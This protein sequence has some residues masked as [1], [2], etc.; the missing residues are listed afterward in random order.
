[1][2]RRDLRDDIERDRNENKKMG[3]YIFL[4]IYF[5]PL[6]GTCQ[7]TIDKSC[8]DSVFI[9]KDSYDNKS[10]VMRT[11]GN[12][13]D[14]SFLII[15]CDTSD[16]NVITVIDTITFV[17]D[18]LKIEGVSFYEGEDLVMVYNFSDN[19]VVSIDRRYEKKLADVNIRLE[20]GKTILIPDELI[21]FAVEIQYLCRSDFK[22]TN[23]I[24]LTPIRS[25]GRIKLQKQRKYMF[26]ITPTINDFGDFIK[27]KDL[28]FEFKF[29]ADVL[30][31]CN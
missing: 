20:Q 19:K 15:E 12:L 11:D 17:Y 1:M 13:V 21:E 3:N 14:A 6:I 26:V 10:I 16:H 28:V 23:K 22:V 27:K 30:S 24:E 2:G 18:S 25:F 29:K 31:H 5:I 9:V 7:I 4:L 8:N